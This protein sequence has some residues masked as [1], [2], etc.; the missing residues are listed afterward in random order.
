MVPTT[1]ASKSATR[2]TAQHGSRG[3]VHSSTRSRRSPISAICPSALDAAAPVIDEAFG[4]GAA[5]IVRRVTVNPGLVRGGVK[6]NMVASECQFE[7]DIRVPNGLTDKQILHEVDKIVARHP[8]ATYKV[9]IYNPPAWTPPDTEM[10]Q[11]VRANARAGVAMSI[12][13]R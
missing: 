9:M 10:A 6:V 8:E 13:C 4:P 5:N 2:I 7:V 3:A 12:R 1:H 11:Y